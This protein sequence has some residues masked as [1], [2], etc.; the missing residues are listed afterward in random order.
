MVL[1]LC[2]AV[3]YG[4]QWILYPLVPGSGI[5]FL[6]GGIVS[7][8]SAVPIFLAAFL[9]PLDGCRLTGFGS[10]TLP[11]SLAVLILVPFA[12]VALRSG[13]EWA[14]PGNAW[15][16]TA[17][18]LLAMAAAEEMVFRGFLVNVLSFRGNFTSGAVLS[19][20]LFALVHVDN[21]GATP[22][23]VFNVA[24]FGFLLV[25]LRRRTRGLAA[26]ILVHWAWN[27]TTGMVFGWSVSGY[28]L[29]SL[30]TSPG[31]GPWSAFGPEGSLLLTAVLAVGIALV[32]SP[33]GGS[34]CDARRV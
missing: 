23:G 31:G 11:L 32:L 24:V 13:L 3:W 34:S 5:P 20:L 19:S 6:A 28:E 33:G 1:V 29:P 17:L 4:L 15:I 26:P 27:L 30:W 21:Y 14:S 8:L 22:L 12:A 2:A 16:A 7:F 10:P 9:F 25:L 18:V